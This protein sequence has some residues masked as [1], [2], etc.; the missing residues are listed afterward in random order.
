M[1]W[2]HLGG[3]VM[4]R[5]G[6][7]IADS[8]P[9]PGA[10]LPAALIVAAVVI[11]VRPL[12]RMSRTVV[13]IAHELGH[14][15]VA[16]LTGR[17]WQRFV[18]HADMSGEVA[19]LGKPTGIGRILTTAAGYPMPAVLGAL[20]IWAG[21]SGWVLVVLLVIA[22]ALVAALVRA[23]SGFTVLWLVFLLLADV[24]LWWWS[25]DIL[26][27]GLVCGLGAFLVGGAW[28]QLIN[29][30]G[31]HDPGQDPA[32]LASISW[33]ARGGWLTVFFAIVGVMTALS[34]RTMA[35]SL[36]MWWRSVMG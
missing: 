6:Q 9:A 36:M 35:P 15:L 30:S 7:S 21:L 23:R 11:G 2:Q 4:A 33:L 16:L 29:V 18:V 13:T 34:A 28:R 12:W 8:G 25:S 27:A 3:L 17:R 24:A 22:V 19:T 26:A 20:A 10:W 14:A 31:S 1:D 32:V 5:L